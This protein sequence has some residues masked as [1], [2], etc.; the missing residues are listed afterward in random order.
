MSSE[1][2][3]NLVAGEIL[4]R[5]TCVC[6]VEGPPL[7]LRA[8]FAFLALARRVVI[9]VS[10]DLFAAEGVPAFFLGQLVWREPEDGEKAPP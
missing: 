10:A 6:N 2:A 4:W 7:F 9:G 1:P 3:E 8:H 5:S